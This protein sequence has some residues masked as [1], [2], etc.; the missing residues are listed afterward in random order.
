MDRS[1]I[2]G[3]ASLDNRGDGVEQVPSNRQIGRDDD[4]QSTLCRDR[5][6]DEYRMV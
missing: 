3:M 6:D 5:D 2:A 1:S 4:D